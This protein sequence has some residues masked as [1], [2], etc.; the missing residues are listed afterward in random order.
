MLIS[1]YKIKL[2]SDYNMEIIKNR[3][4]QNGFKTDGFYGLNFKLYMIS[5]KGK[6]GNEFN[7][8][9]PL[10]FW[11]D[12]E[13][14][15]KF[16]FDGFYD[17]ILGS[18]GWQEVVTFIPLL[19]NLQKILNQDIKYL[20]ELEGDILPNS[21]LK[22][23]KLELMEELKEI[24]DLSYIVCYNPTNW[25]YKVYVLSSDLESLLQ[26]DGEIYQVL[27]VSK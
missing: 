18:F 6:N 10:Y 12:T 17:N 21:T 3:V 15:N 9:A 20:C 5:E 14:L 19:N 22:Q 26:L 24:K 2:P 1:Q 13:G 4:K 23:V 27:Y 16:L 8:Y 11:K 7:S 25:T